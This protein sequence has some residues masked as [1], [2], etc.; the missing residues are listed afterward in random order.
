MGQPGLGGGPEVTET[1]GEDAVTGGQLGRRAVERAL[2]AC[3]GARL[4]FEGSGEQGYAEVRVEHSHF[5]LQVG[6]V[7]R[8]EC[9]DTIVADMVRGAVTAIDQLNSDR[10]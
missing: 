5:E 8:V 7:D 10:E 4:A 2:D 1:S 9:V 3:R 6:Q